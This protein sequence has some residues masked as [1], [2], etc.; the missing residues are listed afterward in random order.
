MDLKIVSE[1]HTTK[2]KINY[3]KTMYYI[4]YKPGLVCMEILKGDEMYH[5]CFA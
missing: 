5:F 3:S 4:L 1:L 2:I